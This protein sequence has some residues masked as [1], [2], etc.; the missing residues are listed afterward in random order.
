MMPRV[1]RTA[2]NETQPSSVRWVPWVIGAA[3]MAALIAAVS[4]LA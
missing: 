4:Q 3:L 1:D 2:E